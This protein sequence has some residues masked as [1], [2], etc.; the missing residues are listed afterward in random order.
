MP[1]LCPHAKKCSGCQLQ[2]MDYEEQ[3]CF[4]QARLVKLLGRY[5]FLDEIIG[6]KNPFHYRNKVQAAFGFRRGRIWSGVYQSATGGL[7]PVDECLLE[8]KNADAIIVT[9]RKLCES[10][11]IQAY[12][13]RTGR[14]FLRHVMVRTAKNG[15][16]M[17]VLVTTTDEFRSKTAFI[18]RLVLRHPEI[19]TIVRNINN[20][21]KGLMLGDKSEV[22]Y[23]DG[24]ITD[25]VCDLVFRVSPKSFFQVNRVQTEV[26]YNKAREF[27]NLHG[28]ERV[29]DA[30][31]GTGTIGLI[32]AR[33]AKTVIGVESN[34][35]A[36]RDAVVNAELN[37]ID[38][39][40][41]VAAD[42]GDF[43]AELAAD[44][45]KI[46]VAITD[47]PRAGCSPKF[48]KNLI[49]LAPKRVV[50]ISCNPETLA[51]DLYTLRNGGYKVQKIQP[52]DMF[53][54]TA[55][56][57]TVALLSKLCTREHIDIE[58]DVEDLDLTA[59]EKKATYQE[60]K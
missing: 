39:I 60:I 20:T 5:T 25:T 52:V 47:P 27:A 44:G 45:T 2:N 33:D 23:G 6:M 34:R 55:H 38:N 36:V 49:T 30:Y 12:D 11:K 58:L 10:F 59:A 15:D 31:C 56:I 24:Y 13:N 32:M 3:L 4:K 46:D 16:T 41:F 35:D 29:L 7:V 17:V 22:L 28:K 19:T 57:E 9:I 50:Y 54:Y 37:G 14:G 40:Q 48:L 21:D 51:R 53:P 1:M 18:K 43:M 42:A 8:D 26:L